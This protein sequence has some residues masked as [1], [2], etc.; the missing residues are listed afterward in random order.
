MLSKNL[1]LERNRSQ[2]K[3]KRLNKVTRV[4]NALMHGDNPK[5]DDND[6]QKLRDALGAL[7]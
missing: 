7:V 2:E 6:T 5:D 4:M 1:V 3:Q